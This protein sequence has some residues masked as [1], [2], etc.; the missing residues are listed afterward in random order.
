MK[1]LWL[2]LLPIFLLCSFTKEKH[3][4]HVGSVEISY[5]QNQRHLKLQDVF[6]WMIWKTD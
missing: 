5:N 1:C 6:F 4:Y 2:F 3:P